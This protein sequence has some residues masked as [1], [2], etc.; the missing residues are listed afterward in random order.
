[1]RAHTIAPVILLFGCG[2]FQKLMALKDKVDSY[3]ND[4][5]ASMSVLGVAPTDDWR[6]DEA[7]AITDLGSGAQATAFVAN[8]GNEGDPD[9]RL[10]I[11][12][13]GLALHDGGGGEFSANGEDGLVYVA[14]AA[15][16]LEISG[17]PSHRLPLDLPPAPSFSLAKDHE[18]GTALTIDLTGQDYDGSLVMVLDLL[19]GGV[20]HEE[21]PSTA[22]ELYDFSH[23]NGEVG[24][25][26]IPASAFPAEGIYGVG[27]AGTW[28]ADPAEFEELNVALSGAFAG[29]FRFRTV[30]TFSDTDLCDS[31]APE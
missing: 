20:T 15:A 1:M 14:D 28:N 5:M 11:D 17:T 29:Q 16:A 10:V 3:T 6:V 4:H 2:D 12:G 18:L 22:S 19:V 31:A 24:V 7:L 30:C 26:T 27:I 23:V 9:V 13:R 21:R 25:L 8:A